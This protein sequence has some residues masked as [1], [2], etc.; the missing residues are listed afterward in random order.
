MSRRSPAPVLSPR[1]FRHFAVITVAVTACIAMFADGEN[2]EALAGPIEQRIARN[3]QLQAEA[4]KLGKRR[5]GATELR[6]R[7][8]GTS[9]L[10][11]A[12]NV[13]TG[14]Q[15]QGGPSGGGPAGGSGPAQ[16]VDDPRSLAP[17]AGE[18]A[19]GADGRV[20]AGSGKPVAA[21]GPSAKRPSGED[22][23]ALVQ[24]AQRRAGAATR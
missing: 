15:I 14:D 1:V 17:G 10:P 16:G 11:F 13:P 22:V 3:H 19:M 21:K 23:E 4:D 12:E 18:I 24:A 20:K 2:R 8:E 6:L 7:E 5:L 9:Y